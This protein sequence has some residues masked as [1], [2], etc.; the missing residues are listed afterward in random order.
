MLRYGRELKTNKIKN[1]ADLSGTWNRNF[2]RPVIFMKFFPLF[3]LFFAGFFLNACTSSNA[4]RFWAKMREESFSRN[5]MALDIPSE[6]FR[7]AGL[8]KDGGGEDL[9][10]YLE[11]DGRAF[12]GGHPTLDPSPGKAQAY[13]LALLDPAPT[14]LY[15]ARIGQFQPEFTGKDFQEYWT[16]KRLAPEALASANQAIDLVLSRTGAKRLHLIGYS[17][18]GG[19]AVLLA[20]NR[21]DVASLVTV[22]GLLDIEWWVKEEGY[23]PLVGSMN[24][25]DNVEK[26][27]DLPQIHFY[28]EKDRI[29]VPAM[30][31]HFERLASF[32]D[33][34]RIAVPTNHWKEWTSLWPGFLRKSLVPLRERSAKAAENAGRK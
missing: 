10:V 4:E 28:G 24:P 20:Q 22:A 11:G 27:C 18:G 2:G 8:L 17:G 14:V 31:R 26:I 13:E 9:V 16:V 21:S 34:R 15:L 29:I 32:S 7:L 12:V 19:L 3:F 1:P 25:A 30:S 23:L 6:P 5:F 33:F